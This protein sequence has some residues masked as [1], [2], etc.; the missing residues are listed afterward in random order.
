MLDGWKGASREII[1]PKTIIPRRVGSSRVEG[2]RNRTRGSYERTQMKT[3]VAVEPETVGMSS[4][5]RNNRSTPTFHKN[6]RP[7]FAGEP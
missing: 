5:R 2:N 6:G 1:E 7:V 3:N 4:T